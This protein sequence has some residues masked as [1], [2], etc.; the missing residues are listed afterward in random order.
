MHN[1]DNV[2]Y[3][4]TE[5]KTAALTGLPSGYILVE[6]GRSQAGDI[7]FYGESLTWSEMPIDKTEVNYLDL[8]IEAFWA[9]A[10]KAN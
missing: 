2:D 1:Y 5:I 7:P 9:L 10:R 3:S 8:P 4:D 6:E